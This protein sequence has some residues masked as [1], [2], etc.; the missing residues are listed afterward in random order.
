MAL[1]FQNCL[2][3]RSD[4]WSEIKYFNNFF[5]QWHNS[6]LLILMWPTDREIDTKLR[7]LAPYL[8]ARSQWFE[9]LYCFQLGNK[10]QILLGVK[11]SQLNRAEI[12]NKRE[13][14]QLPVLP[15]STPT[16][17]KS[18]TDIPPERQREFKR[19][20]GEE[21]GGGLFGWKRGE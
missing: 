1:F 2:I 6:V 17:L 14:H 21:G 4:K 10:I 9:V 8:K 12:R 16:G 19:Q 20:R 7:E 13:R 11:P 18:S 15:T 3:S 5:K